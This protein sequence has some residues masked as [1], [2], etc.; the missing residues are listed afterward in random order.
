M[1]TSSM[2]DA[3][4]HKFLSANK[5]PLIGNHV[6]LPFLPLFRVTSKILGEDWRYIYPIET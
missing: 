3:S 1:V 4:T 5:Q 2:Y 6:P